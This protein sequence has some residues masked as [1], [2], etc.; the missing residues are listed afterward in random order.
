M[1]LD[2]NIFVD[3]LR[4]HNPAREFFNV[5]SKR[6]DILFSAITEAE[7]VAGKECNNEEKRE[8]TLQFLAHWNKVEVSNPIACKAGD[9]T[10]KHDISLPDAIIAA[11]AI[12]NKAEMFTKNLKDF[13]KIPSLQVKAPY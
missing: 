1:L 13:K 11:T 4:G 9:L 8:K 10:R 2:T 6:N 5:I 12:I 3:H 7:L